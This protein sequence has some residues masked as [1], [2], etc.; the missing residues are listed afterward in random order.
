M[1]TKS[2]LELTFLT[3]LTVGLQSCATTYYQVYD[4]ETEGLQSSKEKIVYNDDNC[5]IIYDLWCEQGTLNFLFKNNSET[6]IHIDL[7]QS[8]FIRNG[9]AYDYYVD[10]ERTKSRSI[11]T[12]ASASLAKSQEFYGYQLPLWIPTT[13]SRSAQVT[14]SSSMETSGSVTT[15][16]PKVICIPAKSAKVIKSFNISNYV[17]LDCNNIGLNKPKKESPRINYIKKESPLV[18]R[19]RLVYYV[20]N[21]DEGVTVD[22]SFW[23]SGFTNYNSKIFHIKQKAEDCFNKNSIKT[24]EAHKYKS[25]NRF[26]NK[27]TFEH[28]TGSN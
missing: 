12:G 26:Y 2:F 13:I 19:N 14:E 20:G 23:V 22:N 11:T 17:L 21:S 7:S 1:K 24:I 15:K 8:F 18:F 25:A 6:D 28:T 4:V 9:I 27:Y 3:F 5:E 16:E 10:C